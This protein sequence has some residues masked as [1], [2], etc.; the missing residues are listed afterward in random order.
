[1]KLAPCPTSTFFVTLRLAD[2]RS[3]LLVRQI[4]AFR[5]AMRLTMQ[6]MP[7]AIDA[8]TV[9]PAVTHMILALP[10]DAKDVKAPVLFLKRCFTQLAQPDAD[11]TSPSAFA[12]LWHRDHWICPLNT[13]LDRV[14]HRSVI[15]HA[16]V[17]AGLCAQPQEWP[18]SSLHRDLRVQADPSLR[19]QSRHAG[20]AT[21]QEQAETVLVY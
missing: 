17:E 21:L 14:R 7:F 16:P 15:H 18:H 13:A 5:Q 11:A 2:R 12:S 4:G 10:N 20:K 3:D 6:Q 8:V 19:L 9:M 1:M